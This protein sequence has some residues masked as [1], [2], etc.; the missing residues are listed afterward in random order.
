[1]N[2]K[3]LP[4]QT[5]Q[6]QE[7]N[8][9]PLALADSPFCQ[10]FSDQ[11]CLNPFTSLPSCVGRP[12]IPMP[13][14]GSRRVGMAWPDHEF[15]GA[16]FWEPD[17][18]DPPP[19]FQPSVMTLGGTTIVRGTTF[20]M[21]RRDSPWGFVVTSTAMDR[22]DRVHPLSR[23]LLFTRVARPSRVPTVTSSEARESLG[24]RKSHSTG[25]FVQRGEYKRPPS[26]S[27]AECGRVRLRL[28]GGR[29]S[30]EASIVR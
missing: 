3:I 29:E 18:D 7:I 23:W 9:K 20:S 14:D 24:K 19:F 22:S 13:W 17:V 8:A 16:P 15:D 12:W 4:T 2:N 5:G 1:M 11:I 10:N 28:R 26:A 6:I 30:V 21:L 25:D 27:A